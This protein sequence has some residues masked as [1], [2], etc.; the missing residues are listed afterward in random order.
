MT[1]T[2]G[3]S[4]FSGVAE[5]EAGTASATPAFSGSRGIVSASRLAFLR[6]SRLNGKIVTGLSMVLIVVAVGYL[7]PFFVDMD[8]ADVASVLPDQTP[9]TEH[10]LG[11]QVEGRDMLAWLIASIPQTLRVGFL[12]G[13][14]GVIFGAAM[15]FVAGYY[16]GFVDTILR[17]FTD[18]MLIVPGLLVLV[19]L[20]ALVDVLTLEQ[21]AFVIAAFAWMGAARTIR[22]QT[23]SLRERQYVEIAKMSGENGL[24]I[25]FFELMPN[26]MPYLLAAFVGAV[27]TSVGTSIA[28]FFLGL[29]PVSLDTLGSILYWAQS[30]QATVIGYWWWWGPPVVVLVIIFSGL[31][32][33]SIGLDEWANPRLKERS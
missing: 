13:S 5:A 20:T 24:Y 4:D 19:V 16:Q 6:P 31:F 32:I 7:G 17:N 30:Y 11:T 10:W 21:M 29:A 25:V 8:N 18:I 27:I 15:G 9:N 26:M 12:A 1:E 22:A 2:P 3:Q 23:L 14:L 28:L 33:A